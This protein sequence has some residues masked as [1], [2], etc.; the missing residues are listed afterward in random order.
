MGEQAPAQSIHDAPLPSAIL[1]DQPFEIMVL[2]TGVPADQVNDIEAILNN[3]AKETIAREPSPTIFQP[4]RAL[5]HPDGGV[6]FMIREKWESQAAF[7]RHQQSDHQRDGLGQAAARGLLKGFRV[8]F[9]TP[10][11]EGK[12]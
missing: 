5:Q 4:Y 11:R 9:M 12:A 2:I 6:D 10:L 1:G 3:L 8:W 7:E